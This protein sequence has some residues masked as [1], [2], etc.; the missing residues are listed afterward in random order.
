[1]LG[2]GGLAIANDLLGMAKGMELDIGIIDHSKVV[3]YS[4]IKYAF[5]TWNL[6]IYVLSYSSLSC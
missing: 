3:S 1:M 6:L 4:P 5:Q 2:T